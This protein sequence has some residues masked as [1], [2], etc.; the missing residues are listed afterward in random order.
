MII[1]E[2]ESPGAAMV[3]SSDAGSGMM[4]AE[5]NSYDLNLESMSRMNEYE[6]VG[7]KEAS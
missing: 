6:G 5:G 1:E 2:I 4:K 3:K 7:I